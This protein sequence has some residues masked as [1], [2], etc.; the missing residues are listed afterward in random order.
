MSDLREQ[1]AA[2]EH[3]QWVGWMKYLFEK[4][5]EGG[6]GNVEIPA[7]L[8]D[9]WKRQMNTSYVDLPENEK[10]SDRAEADKVLRVIQLTNVHNQHSQRSGPSRR[11]NN[12]KKFQP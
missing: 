11:P 5:T 8:V 9:R 4:S 3:G 6:D 10:E 7:I 12:A 2:L 1:L